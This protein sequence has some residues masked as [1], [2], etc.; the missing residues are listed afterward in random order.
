ML[1][2]GVSHCTAGRSGP[3]PPPPTE[4]A[5]RSLLGRQGGRGLPL[6]SHT[7][8]PVRSTRVFSRLDEHKSSTASSSTRRFGASVR[9]RCGMCHVC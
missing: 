5:A 2:F 1:S 3:P 7:A 9:F 6:Q 8:G 4:Q